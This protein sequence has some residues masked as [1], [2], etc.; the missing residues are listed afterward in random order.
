M[1]GRVTQIGRYAVKSMQGE[2]PTRV[3]VGPSGVAGDRVHAIV[4]VES[5]KIASAKD[6]RAWGQLFQSR[7]VYVDEPAVGSPLEITLSDGRRVRSDAPGV[8]DDLS[9]AFGRAVRLSAATPDAMP[10]YDLVWEN[11]DIEYPEHSRITLLRAVPPT[12]G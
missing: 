8:D 12:T 1:Q 3:E 9:E 2:A 5:G 11:T 10:L 4:D 6:P 7:A